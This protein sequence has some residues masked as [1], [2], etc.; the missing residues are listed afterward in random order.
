MDIPAPFLQV[1][2]EKPV[3][4]HAESIGNY[5]SKAMLSIQN[6][7]IWIIFFS[8]KVDLMQETTCGLNGGLLE[9]IREDVVFSF[10]KSYK[11]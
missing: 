11:I 3:L 9:R 1:P 4:P 6:I 8:V 10:S 2:H 7:K 5:L